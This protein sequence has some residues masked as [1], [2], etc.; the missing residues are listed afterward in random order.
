MDDKRDGRVLVTGGAGYI[1]SHAVLALHEAGV[2]CIVVDDLSTGRRDAL[3]PDVPF[4]VGD[5]AD[6]ALMADV[7]GRHRVTA[8]L[9]FA[10]SISVPE[11]VDRPLDYYRNNT[12]TT[13]ALVACCVANRV[14][15][16][17]FSSTAAVYGEPEVSPVSEEAD[18]RPLNPYG[19]SKLMAEWI[20]RDAERAH[21][22][23][24]VILRYFNV[25]GADAGSRA[26]FTGERSGHLVKVACE[27]ALGRRPALSIFGTDYPTRDGTCVRD[28]VHVSDLAAAHVAALRHLSAGGAS[29]TLNCGYGRGFSVREVV[30]AVEAVTGRE[31]PVTTAPRRQGDAAEVVSDARRIGR[32]LGWRPALDDLHLIVRHTLAWQTRHAPGP[33]A[34]DGAG[35]GIGAAGRASMPGSSP[36]AAVSA[37]ASIR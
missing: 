9:H 11:S 27:T 30:A 8:V 22:L 3:A 14:E 37:V 28:F 16:L 18:T 29:A 5:A 31:L 12:E 19:S 15:R 26:G 24:H 33:F 23:R 10:G 25:A 7:I 20:L 34:A 6:H 36:P 21:G 32:L 1:G 2:P 17:V 35:P 13:R 4:V